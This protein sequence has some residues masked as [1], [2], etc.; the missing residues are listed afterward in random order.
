MLERESRR[1]RILEAKSREIKLKSKTAQ[2]V[3]PVQH[4]DEDENGKPKLTTE[5][6]ACIASEDEYKEGL[7]KEQ[8]L[9]VPDEIEEK[10]LPVTNNGSKI[11][12]DGPENEPSNEKV[13]DSEVE[14]IEKGGNEE[15]NDN[16]DK[17]KA[18][19]KEK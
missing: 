4:H 11:K 12:D 8:K 7:A 2:K 14:A 15:D 16:E 10:P 3:A 19:E 5:Q 17:A 6:I 1:E 9:R 18:D 13:A